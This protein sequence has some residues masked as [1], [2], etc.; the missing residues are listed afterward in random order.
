[1]STGSNAAILKAL[2]ANSGIAVAKFAGWLFT[3]S[4]AMLAEAIHS[5]ADCANQALLL[6]GQ[7]LANAPATEDHPMGNYRAVYVLS[8]VVALLLFFVGGVFS[9]VEGIEHFNH[10]SPVKHAI[11]AMIILGVSVILEGWSLHGALKESAEERGDRSFV[12]WFKETRQSDLLVVTG[13]DIAALG[14]LFLAFVAVAASYITGD[15]R[16]DAAGSI[17]VGALL[18]LVAMFVFKEV[19]GL[20]IGESVEPELRAEIKQ[21]VVDQ[22]EVEKIYN[23]FAMAMGRKMFIALKVKLVNSHAITGDDVADITDA[24]EERIQA[25]FPAAKWIFFET[26]RDRPAKIK[27]AA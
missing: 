27:K 18:M 11:P 1:M 6:F 15:P 17:G 5:L 7:K 14:G 12:R 21:F 10:P 20:L 13:E 19:Y 9:F 4:A 16:Y 23:M 22:P 25:Q 24:V 3:G 8:M 2:G 26:D